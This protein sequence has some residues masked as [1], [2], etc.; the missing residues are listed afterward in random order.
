MDEQEE[1]TVGENP[2]VSSDGVFHR[3]RNSKKFIT[4]GVL[5]C[6]NLLNYMDRFTI[7]GVLPS[8]KAYFDM[9][10]QQAGILQTVFIVFY[11]V[12]APVCGYLG[13][14]TNR[15]H[16][17]FV[18]YLIWICAV[19]LSTFVGQNNLFLFMLLRG[20]VGV[21]ESSYSTVAP[22]II[23]DMFTDR[24]RS[25]SLM[26]FYFAIP[27]GSGLGYIGGS[28]ISFLFGGW[29]AGVRFTACIAV[30]LIIPLI[31][32]VEIPERGAAEHADQLDA[33]DGGLLSD[34][35]YLLTIKTYIFSTIGF[36]C[37]IFAVGSLSWWTPTLMGY[38]Y[39]RNG[40]MSPGDYA[41]ISLIFGGIT[42]AAGIFGVLIGSSWAQAWR[43]GKWGLQKKE[44][45]DA[46]VCAVGSMLTVPLLFFCLVFAKYNIVTSWV[47][48]FLSVTCMCLNWSVNMDMLMYV[49][50]ANRRATATA[51]Q[52]LFSHLLGD[53]SSPY[54]VGLISDSIKGDR[55]DLDMQFFALQTALFVPIF[56]LVCSGGFYLFSGLYV[57]KD[58][59]EAKFMMTGVWGEQ[60]DD[61]ETL[62]SHSDN[63][64]NT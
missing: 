51:I 50:V 52:T 16:I 9:N 13:D 46:Y 4:F 15:L 34:I 45:A 20:I 3:L 36:T 12:C 41:E 33:H 54:V 59:R 26:I 7:A 42:C 35:R 62:I 48:M 55:T 25:I 57:S 2:D 63:E 32:F 6:V 22:S 11:M 37:V 17:L 44:N 14:R 19:M 10:D 64:D 39:G 38:A 58:H 30:V 56:L 5:F 49:T 24:A 31:Y 28:S 60:E 40:A 53:A 23:A 21:G 18:G 47:L 29:Q 1:P 61:M 27:V 43:E 8:L